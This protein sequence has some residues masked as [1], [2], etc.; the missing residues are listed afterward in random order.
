MSTEPKPPALTEKTNLLHR[1][2]VLLF[3]HCFHSWGDLI[4]PECL[5]TGK[6]RSYKKNPYF[7]PGEKMEGAGH[8]LFID[9]QKLLTFLAHEVK[10]F[11]V[12]VIFFSLRLVVTFQQSSFSLP[13]NCEFP[14]LCE[15]WPCLFAWP[16]FATCAFPDY[17]DPRTV[18]YPS[19]LIKRF[20]ICKPLATRS[21]IRV[22]FF[23][24]SAS[25]STHSQALQSVKGQRKQ[26]CV[27]NR[28]WKI[29][30]VALTVLL[31]QCCLSCRVFAVN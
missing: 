30:N 5:I 19:L 23:V 28:Q 10:L 17:G 21:R 20:A 26:L 27:N 16:I 22:L 31:V 2:M 25:K 4:C 18:P 24:L 15:Y 1:S 29:S 13:T 9:F 11:F 8:R 6:V 3:F 7:F 12:C 14:P